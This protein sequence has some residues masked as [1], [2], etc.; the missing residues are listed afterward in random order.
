[1]QSIVMVSN[2]LQV[3]RLIVSCV[4]FSHE[5][6]QQMRMMANKESRGRSGLGTKKFEIALIFQIL[7]QF[8]SLSGR[9][10]YLELDCGVVE[11]ERL[12]E[13][14]RAYGGLL[15]LVELTLDKPQHQRRLPYRRLSE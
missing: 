10:P 8:S 15:E 6:A 7:G 9:V 11:A 1:M 14:G 3:N 4:I 13:E 2:F 5:G 12:R